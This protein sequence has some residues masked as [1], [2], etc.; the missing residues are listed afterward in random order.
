M[1]VTRDNEGEKGA[2]CAG[3][4]L[5]DPWVIEA[6]PP[7][8]INSP[9][10]FIFAEHHR[11]RQA[12][13]ILNLIADGE[14]DTKGVNNL[15]AFLEGDFALHVGDEELGFF[16]I[17]RQLCQPE[18]NIDPLIARL[19][20]EHKDDETISDDIIERLKKLRLGVPL[21][22]GDKRRIHVFAEHL[23]QHLALE[24]AVLLPIARVRMDDTALSTLS[25]T[26]KQR[27][28][29]IKK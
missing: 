11:Q 21:D 4:D 3:F 22:K 20:E 28:R 23:R 14:F 27:R 9:L 2:P 7:A 6:M 13:M 25:Y 26:L 16:P 24:N 12:A 17:L 18:D 10:D 15:I 8:L 1:M 19:V 29:Q 5:C